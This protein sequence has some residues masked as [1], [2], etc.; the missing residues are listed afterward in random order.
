MNLSPVEAQALIH[1]LQN[2][3]ITQL[4]EICLLEAKCSVLEQKIQTIEAQPGEAQ[5]ASQAVN[6]TCT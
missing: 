6:S 2:R 3:L 5:K 4:N 1:V